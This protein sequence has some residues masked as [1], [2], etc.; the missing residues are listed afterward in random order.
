MGGSGGGV[1]GS[2]G[3]DC[4]GD[5]WLASRGCVSSLVVVLLLPLD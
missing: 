1:G 3:G 5:C 4:G 2:G